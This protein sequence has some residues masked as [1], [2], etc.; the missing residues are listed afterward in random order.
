MFQFAGFASPRLCDSGGDDPTRAGF[1]HSE[2]RGSKFARNSPRLIATCYVLHRLSVP[3]HSPD[4]L[5]RLIASRHAQG[6]ARPMTFRS[7]A[8]ALTAGI[9]VARPQGRA[10]GP[11]R[12]GG[13]ACSI[14]DDKYP[15][16]SRPIPDGGRR[17]GGR[18]VRRVPTSE[19]GVPAGGPPLVEVNGFEPMTSCLQSR[20]SPG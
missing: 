11:H 6:R 17:A 20:R 1:P 8:A 14:H 16:R 18:R 13:L 12:S 3:R 7:F 19:P 15:G 9:P 2:I 10:P 4:A 5:Q